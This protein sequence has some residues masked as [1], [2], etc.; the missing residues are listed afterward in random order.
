MKQVFISYAR[1][2]EASCSTLLKH[3][4]VLRASGLIENWHCGKLDPGIDWKK[5]VDEKLR[6]ADII[7]MLVS[8]DFLASEYCHEV[9]L[10]QALRRW[11]TDDVRITPVIVRACA[12]EASPIGRLQVLPDK[13]LPVSQWPHEDE[14]WTAVTRHIRRIASAHSEP[15]GLG[16]A[17]SPQSSLTPRWHHVEILAGALSSVLVLFAYFQTPQQRQPIAVWLQYVVVGGIMLAAHTHLF[18]LP[19]LLER[20]HANAEAVGRVRRLGVATSV[21][22]A[23]LVL[24]A[25]MSSSGI[26]DS[27]AS[28]TRQYVP[29]SI[30]PVATVALAVLAGVAMG[31]LVPKAFHALVRRD[32]A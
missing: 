19:Y 9:E 7:I 4:E 17:H 3:L 10:T 5:T 6:H 2:D 15:I 28:L 25:V 30:Q 13:A 14:A 1:E 20:Y 12:W 26:V 31:N 11:E 8:A 23:S 27:I 22:T 32:R 21:M 18:L 29:P 16:T 24:I